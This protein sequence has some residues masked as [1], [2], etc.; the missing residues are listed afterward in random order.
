VQPATAGF[1]WPHSNIQISSTTESIADE[2]YYSFQILPP[3]VPPADSLAGDTA[4]LILSSVMM[5][6][7]SATEGDDALAAP[8]H[9]QS[10][11]R[12]V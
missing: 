9:L 11:S 8:K 7:V 12:Y 3:S 2:E 5:K 6:I 4:I 10:Y 1:V